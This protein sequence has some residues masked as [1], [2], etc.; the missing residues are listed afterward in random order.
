ME[1]NLGN[2]V[3]ILTVAGFIGGGINIIVIKPLGGAIVI[4][5]DTIV[6]FKD[7]IEKM[8]DA[9]QDID[10]RLVRVEESTKSAHHRIDGLEDVVKHER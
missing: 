7:T 8:K 10:K 2:L 9:Q 1:I 6:E 4:L 3:Q 5:K